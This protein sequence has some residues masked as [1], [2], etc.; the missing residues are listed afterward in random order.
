MK[1][2]ILLVAAAAL[3]LTACEKKIREAH[4]PLPHPI[5]AR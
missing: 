1:T 3:T 4:A 2:L 5:A